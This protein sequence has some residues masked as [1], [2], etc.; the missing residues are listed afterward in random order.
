M[1][2]ERLDWGN[3]SDGEPL[4]L[5]ILS[6]KN[7]EVSIS[8]LG[9]IITSLKVRDKEGKFVDVVLGF[10]KPED[11]INDVN[12][13]GKIVGRNCNRIANGA[14]VINEEKYNLLQNDGTNNLHSEGA[15]VVN[16]IMKLEK[17]DAENNELVLSMTDEE[18]ENGFPGNLKLTYSYK[19]SDDRL[20]FTI[21]GVSDKDTIANFTN[22]GYFNLSGH[23]NYSLS[24]IEAKIEADKFQPVDRDMLPK[25]DY[26]QVEGTAFDFREWKGITCD[27]N[28]TDVVEQLRIAGGYDHSF[29]F[30]GEGVRKVAGFRSKVTGIEMTVSTNAPAAQFYTSN[31]FV[32]KKGKKGAYYRK[33][34]AFAFEPNF[35]P[36]A[37]NSNNEYVEKPILKKD[38]NYNYV[39]EY[40]FNLYL[41]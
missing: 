19:L 35:V 20:I 2:I 14:F 18:V 26:R 12:Y 17:M 10:S 21:N 41:H 3:S 24:D 34:G 23:D 37:I 7:I 29:I 11:Y 13:V 9:G 5:Y 25:G 6:E 40:A 16:K 8:D 31:M 38:E 22:H 30:C 36:N 4:S 27:I 33:R 15:S 32:E 39:I 1:M 28:D